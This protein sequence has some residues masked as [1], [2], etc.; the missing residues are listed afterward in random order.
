MDPS[1]KNQYRSF[2]TRN[3]SFFSVRFF[4]LFSILLLFAAIPVIILTVGKQTNERSRA[5]G[6]APSISPTIMLADQISTPTA[7]IIP[8]LTITPTLIATSTPTAVMATPPV[9]PTAS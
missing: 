6:P 7:T 1:E 8:T 9:T 2:Y 3:Q 5:S 4:G